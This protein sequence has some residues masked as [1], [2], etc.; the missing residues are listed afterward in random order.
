MIN[1]YIRY[2]MNKWTAI[3]LHQQNALF[4]R[5]F[6]E[7][8]PCLVSLAQKNALV[9]VNGEEM[10]ELARPISHKVIH[11]SG[12]GIP[13][14]KPL[15]EKLEKIIAKGEKG[16]VYLSFGSLAN[17]SRFP[18]EKKLAILEAFA[19][20]PEYQFIWK[21]EQPENDWHL[22][23]NYT[24]IHPVKWTPQVDLLNHPKM[25]AFITHGG[26]N[27]V[28]EAIHFATP[29]VA[30]PLFGDQEHNVAT[31]VKRGVAVSIDRKKLTAE[32]LT[33]ALRQVLN[34]D[35]FTKNAETLAAMIAKKPMK[36]KELVVKW[37][38][39]VAEFK[40][41]SNL[42]LAGRD[43]GF[44]KNTIS[45]KSTPEFNRTVKLPDIAVCLP[46]Q[47]NEIIESL[48]NNNSL[49]TKSYPNESLIFR[50]ATPYNDALEEFLDAHETWNDVESDEWP[51]IVVYLA[52]YYLAV[53]YETENM[54]IN[55]RNPMAA[56]FERSSSES[57][58]IVDLLI[59]ALNRW[60]RNRPPSKQHK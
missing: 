53:I 6:G 58:A 36:P 11:I 25:K 28:T 8:F 24:N 54:R 47:Y 44:I 15:D 18:L 22:F 45:L 31:A 20:F 21:Y 59:P 55:D 50:S 4:R 1:L 23:E 10:F 56:L 30:I 2:I 51:F 14:P 57:T 5:Y 48:K 43:F 46:I 9:L 38:E 41:L 3:F 26:M 32:T 7:D 27:S 49:V 42:D 33:N 60:D 19:S 29:M 37:T 35:S 16:A 40:D 12:I 52:H 39:F 17:C 34:D 13:E